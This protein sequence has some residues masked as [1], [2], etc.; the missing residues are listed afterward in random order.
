MNP[1]RWEIIASAAR[2]AAAAPH[3]ERGGIIE[4]AATLLNLSVKRTHSL[5]AAA[6]RKL[7]LAPERKRRSDA[8]DSAIADTELE[9]IA[10]VL[11]R[12]QR[13][14]KDMMTIEAAI[15][16]LYSSG[17]IAARLSV[18]QV[19][20]LLK[21]RGMDRRTLA[22]PA[23]HVRMRVEHINA[24][25]QIDASVCVLYRTPKG[26]TLILEEGV[27]YK[28]KP[29]N[30]QR[31]MDSLLTRFVC[32]EVA[33]HAIAVRYYIGGERVESA[34]D[35]L[36]WVMTQRACN[37]NPMPLH[38]VP[39]MLYT[40][41]GSMFKAAAWRNFCGAMSIRHEMHAPGNSQAT[42]SVETAQNIVE[43]G[44]EARLRFI[45]PLSITVDRLNL[46]AEQW[47]HVR[48][49]NKTHSRHKMTPYAAWST[50]RP[51]H[52]R[53]APSLDIM[54]ALPVSLAAPRTVSGN[55]TVSYAIKGQGSREYN[56]RYVPGI[57]PRDKVLVAINPLAAPAARVG[58]TDR[59]TGEILWHDV[60]PLETGWMGYDADAPVLGKD[61]Y[62]ALP[63]T[64]AD[65]LR[66]RI[67]AQ[68][69]AQGDK[70]V[71]AGEV[72][73]AEKAKATPYLGQFDP[74]ADLAAKAAALPAFFQRPG[75]A[76]ATTAV[77]VEPARLSVADACKRLKT[78]L[79]EAYQPSTYAWLSRQ[80]GEAGVPEDVVS[81]MIAA[82]RTPAQASDTPQPGL[83]VIGGVSHGA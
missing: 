83:R 81:G 57:S 5:V 56:L 19:C 7:G 31:V 12:S 3:G 44:L 37:D 73:A 51:E 79:G 58:V 70:P 6:A 48:N 18:S 80:H 28:N 54:R 14:G 65:E 38:G 22:T 42:G 50:I 47:M 43:R 52:L 64:P 59:D 23:P 67:K 36:M 33:S 41:Q 9:L 78:A 82:H 16:M 1:V 20:R 69:F 71:T 76:H 2:E 4:R 55:L 53:L 24:V 60:Q 30:I 72:E 77:N 10:G 32:T 29:E 21:E 34:L 11:N 25:W 66:A 17:Q 8:G 61:D 68:A 62:K 26:E 40:D 27:H 49:G 45:D 39:F 63:A 13:N 74:L 46:L 75:T 15:D 35:F